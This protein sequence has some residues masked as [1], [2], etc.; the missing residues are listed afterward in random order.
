MAHAA[1]PAPDP[2]SLLTREDVRALP[3]WPE[4]FR[5]LRKD[6]RYYEI[7]EQTICPDFDFRYL[8]IR[9]A[10]GQILA[11]QPAFFLD[12]D[13]LAGAGARTLD[14]AQRIRAVW[15]GMLK[16]RT[17][18]VGC[19]AGE[20]HLCIRPGPERTQACKVLAEHLTAL[21]RRAGASLVVLKEFPADDREALAPFRS[22]GFSVV[23]S[24][25]MT[26][27]DLA[28]SRSFEDFVARRLSK[29]RR[30]QIRRNLRATESGPPVTYDVRTDVADI[31]E[32]IFPLYGQVYARARMRFERLT[33][34]YFIEIGRRMPETARFFVWWRE[35]KAVAFS[36][37]LVE[38]D[39]L[40]SEYLGFDY[41]LALD[42]HLYFVVVRDTIDWAIAHG[43]RT[44]VSSSLGYRPKL[45]LGHL[46]APIDLYVRHTSSIANLLLRAVHPLL[47]PTR[48]DA[49][50]RQFP[51]FA[52]LRP[53]LARPRPGTAAGGGRPRLGENVAPGRRAH[54]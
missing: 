15:P 24:M 39:R 20:G 23:P 45:R 27:L 29:N 11:I 6:S 13:V 37:Y 47:D 33:P 41:S 28:Q 44:I 25:P 5:G 32:Q 48:G 2:V 49:V 34:A 1:A 9:D 30:H 31:I 43:F 50:L 42:L 7:V 4:A 3:A 51:N 10:D 36:L 19:A 12:Q 35:G 17:L 16:L 22:A 14:L 8:A 53:D 26:R 54:S 46:L 21:A 52:D 38:D 40:Y 18:M